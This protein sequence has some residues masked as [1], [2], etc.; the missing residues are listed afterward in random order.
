MAEQPTPTPDPSRSEPSWQDFLFFLGFAFLVCHEIDAVAQHEWR[1]LPIL[2]GLDDEVAYPWFV[3]LHAPLLA[4]MLW[5]TTHGS[6]V[7]RIRSR[8]GLDLFFALHAGIHFLLR[9]DELA[10]FDTL[11]S[12]ICIYSAGAIGLAHALLTLRGLRDAAPPARELEV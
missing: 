11:T 12:Q 4:A 3:L 6:R 9:Y 10:P 7:L 8:V 2:G 1:L 5:A